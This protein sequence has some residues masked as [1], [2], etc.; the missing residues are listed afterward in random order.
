MTKGKIRSTNK[1]FVENITKETL[2]RQEISE[3]NQIKLPTKRR[4][5]NNN[6]QQL[7]DLA[8]NSKSE[9]SLKSKKKIIKS[10]PLKI[11]DSRGIL[12]ATKKMTKNIKDEKLLH[13]IKTF[14]KTEINLDL[15]PKIPDYSQL[16]IF[17]WNVNGIRAIVKKGNIEEF[18]EKEKP[19]IL[20]LN[21]TKIDKETLEKIK[22]N[23]FFYKSGYASYWNCSKEKK[24]Y[25]GVAILTKFKPLS[26]KYGLDIEEHNLEGRALTVEYP[27]FL[28]VA[29]YVPN[30]G[31]GCKRLDY[32]VK[33][34]DIAL[35]EYLIKLKQIK[36]VILCGD[37]NV[38]HNEID[39]RH[40][41]S[42]EGCAC[43]TMEERSSF[44]DHL[45]SGFIDT[46][47]HLYPTT[48]KYSYFCQRISKCIEK[49]VGWRLD[50]FI[51]NKEGLNRLVDSEISTQYRGSDHTPIKLIWKTC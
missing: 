15:L 6:Q 11:N 5:T 28:I 32:R 20:C 35:R 44:T 16:N 39:L 8:I 2:V 50:Y 27:N 40:P 25:S 30:S 19:D 45:N 4:R 22:L 51:I 12:K 42:N 10:K 36:D 49:N 13:I 14:G 3:N 33:K 7:P 46:F 34:W 41:K 48:V 38:A 37:M 47:R 1:P 18:I 17:S 9:K 26:V 31:D 43:F 29:V 24:G 21:E 23:Q